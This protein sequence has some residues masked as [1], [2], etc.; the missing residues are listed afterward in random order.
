MRK[1]ILSFAA[2]LA[3]LVVLL[4]GNFA[5]AG[6]SFISCRFTK[7]VTLQVT[8]KDGGAPPEG[9]M[10][11]PKRGRPTCGY[12]LALPQS[13]DLYASGKASEHT[14]AEVVWADA[15]ETKKRLTLD[16][17]TVSP[18]YYKKGIEVPVRSDYRA[19]IQ[20]PDV[21]D[22]LTGTCHSSFVQD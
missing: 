11:L 12:T 9:C 2:S 19:T 6:K 8:A 10:L 20:L 15:P 1:H 13:I 7:G 5:F 18:A 4:S 3:G 16:L 21:K 17:A 22:A 14:D